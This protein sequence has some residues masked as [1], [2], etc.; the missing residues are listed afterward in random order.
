MLVWFGYLP[1]DSFTRVYK[2]NIGDGSLCLVITTTVDHNVVSGLVFKHPF[3]WSA[4]DYANARR[5]GMNLTIN[6]CLHWE[7]ILFSR[8][9]PGDL[10]ECAER[11]FALQLQSPSSC[12]FSA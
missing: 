5:A 11:T 4:K 2:D 8:I 3:P 1:I 7:V 10:L 9:L 12:L 6:V